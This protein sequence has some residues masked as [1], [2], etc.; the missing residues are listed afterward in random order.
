MKHRYFLISLLLPV[1]LGCN[2]LDLDIFEKKCSTYI[3]QKYKFGYQEAEIWT[4]SRKMKVG[5]TIFIRAHIPEAIFDS[6]SGRPVAVRGRFGLFFRLSTASYFTSTSPFA[7]DT[8]IVRVFHTYF[9]TFVRNGKQTAT[10]SFEAINQGGFWN[11]NIGFVAKRKGAFDIY[12]AVDFLQTEEV[13]PKSTCML[14]DSE[15]YNAMIRIRSRNNR[16]NEIYPVL[17]QGLEESFGFIVE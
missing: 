1:C 8:T 16:I 4:T 10:Y 17:P 2:F 3:P 13:L 14:G 11:L 9:D 7:V 5:D 15:K 12:P 6:L